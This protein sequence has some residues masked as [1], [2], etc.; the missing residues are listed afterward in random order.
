M[1]NSIKADTWV[2]VV[3]QEP[4]GNGQILG[5]QD[6]EKDLSFIPT[7][8]DKEEA[9][10]A[11]PHLVRDRTGKYEI[12]AIQFNNLAKHAKESGFMLFILNGAG[13]VL[14]KMTP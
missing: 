1:M 13:E 11:L 5:Q 7:F 9:L 14:D 3:I 10:Q 4:D 2:W 8:F 12:Q 6:Q